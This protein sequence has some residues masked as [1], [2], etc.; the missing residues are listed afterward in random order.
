MAPPRAWAVGVLKI[1]VEPFSLKKNQ[2]HPIILNLPPGAH[3]L[4]PFKWG[5]QSLRMGEHPGD[6]WTSGRI[7]VWYHIWWA[8]L[9]VC[10]IYICVCVCE[11]GT[12]P[13]AFLKAQCPSIQ[14]NR[15]ER[16]CWGGGRVILI[17]FIGY[18]FSLF[19]WLWSPTLLIQM[20]G[21]FLKWN[22][23]EAHNKN[24]Y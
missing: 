2:L 1:L 9:W 11:E 20:W 21:Q 5:V 3:K 14:L 19:K 8:T 10:T 6:V 13:R 12:M 7:C 23:L 24:W 4:S 17:I 15:E 18:V 22:L 16:C